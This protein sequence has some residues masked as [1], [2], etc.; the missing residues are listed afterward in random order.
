VD[1]NAP[2]R[3]SWLVFLRMPSGMVTIETGAEAKAPD[4]LKVACRFICNVSLLRYA[5]PIP[6]E[7]KARSRAGKGLC[8]FLPCFIKIICSAPCVRDG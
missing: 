8:P 4:M 7:L 6:V 2:H 5:A 1:G 3:P